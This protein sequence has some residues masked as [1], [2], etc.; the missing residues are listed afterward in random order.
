MLVDQASN[1]TNHRKI[2]LLLAE[3]MEEPVAIQVQSIKLIE[4]GIEGCQPNIK[5]IMIEVIDEI[6]DLRFCTTPTQRRDDKENSRLI[7][8]HLEVK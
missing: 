2:Q 8:R 1:A 3:Q 6:D 5:P 7:L 4:I